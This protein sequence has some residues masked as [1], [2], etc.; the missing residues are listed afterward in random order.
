[1]KYTKHNLKKVEGIFE[2]IGYSVRYEKGSFQSGHCLVENKKIVI[3][4]RFFDTEGR[5]A[6]LVEILHT[7]KIDLERLEPKTRQFYKKLLIKPEEN[8]AV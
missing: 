8:Q 1:M 4:N 3:V 2:E 7:L 5:M 6:S